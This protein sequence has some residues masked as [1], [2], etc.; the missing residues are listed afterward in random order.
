VYDGVQN[1]L[2]RPILGLK[3]SEED[4]DTPPALAADLGLL[5]RVMATVAQRARA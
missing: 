5:Q 2:V 3:L 4:R 1:E